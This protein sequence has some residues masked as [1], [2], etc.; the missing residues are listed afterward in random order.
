MIRSVLFSTLVILST[1]LIELDLNR[2]QV[3][4]HKIKRNLRT[5]YNYMSP[6]DNRQNYQYSISIYVGEQRQKVDLIID[7]GS[8]WTW[9]VGDCPP[10]ECSGTP[11][12]SALSSTFKQT[13][14]LYDITYGIGYVEGLI[15]ED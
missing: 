8:S 10:T 4:T 6:V 3:D 14:K 2:K 7:T 12:E 13:T 1:G 9:L 5:N 15:S 11:Y